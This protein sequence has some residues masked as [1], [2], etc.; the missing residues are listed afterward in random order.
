MGEIV[1]FRTSCSCRG[2]PSCGPTPAEASRPAASAGQVRDARKVVTRV[3]RQLSK[4]TAQEQT[5]HEQLL[6]NAADHQRLTS[7][8]AELRAVQ[9]RR[10]ELEEE[11][12]LAAAV[13][14][15]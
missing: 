11:W 6:E 15:G 12:L 9:A 1:P 3:E 4:L 7:L 8:D 2:V 14:E 10:A 13:L 5:L